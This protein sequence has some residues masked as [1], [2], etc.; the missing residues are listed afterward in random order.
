MPAVDP[1]YNRPRKHKPP[2]STP[3]NADTGDTTRSRPAPSQAPQKA[4]QVAPFTRP[5]VEKP[6]AQQQ[7]QARQRTQFAQRRT[8]APRIAAPP[9]I[10]N[11]TASQ[12]M[13]A[14][15][16]IVASVRR[17]L[18]N[19]TGQARQQRTRE[20]LDRIHTDPRLAH[21]RESI[22]HWQAE[23]AKL[24]RP[25]TAARL[26]AGPPPHRIGVGVGPLH[27]ATVN[28]TAVGQA[29]ARLGE[30]VAPGLHVPDAPGAFVKNA[31]GDLGT[32][33]KGPFVA[34]VQLAGIGKDVG[35]GHPARAASTVGQLGK[36]VVQGTI[37]DW[38]HPGRYLREHPV[39]FGL[40]VAG[41]ES[42]VGRTAGA[43]A[44][45]AK[46]ERAST[47]R[48]PLALGEDLAAGDRGAEGFQGSDPPRG[49]EGR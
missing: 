48:P 21:V 14:H 47:V 8:P 42:V 33:A 29:A 32:I 35:T 3:H 24:T 18:G 12:V 4:S 41:A 28:T 11:P 37:H 46:V 1:G 44:R 10:H 27:L 16:Q 38:S 2:R 13:A 5:A 43:V 19:T 15:A 30:K 34:G 9:I 26:T 39:L 49:S 25:Q 6:F 31:F 20:I 23:Q 45:A 40:D 7:T 17:E 22:Q 36:A